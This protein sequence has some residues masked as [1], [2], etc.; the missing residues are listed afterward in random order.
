MCHCPL[1]A[2]A[3]TEPV[4]DPNEVTAPSS[5]ITIPATS[6]TDI[7]QQPTENASEVS[8]AVGKS[9]SLVGPIVGG[10]VG[11]IMFLVIAIGLIFFL[12]RREQRKVAPSAAYIRAHGGKLPTYRES[13]HGAVF[14]LGR[15][16]GIDMT[17]VSLSHFQG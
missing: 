9:K 14:P 17:E 1:K 16:K 3:N 5:S 7:M 4:L 11:G 12:I 2:F 6:S 10:V 8:S 13:M 15:E